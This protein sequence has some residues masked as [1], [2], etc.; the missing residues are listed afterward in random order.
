MKLY[1]YLQRLAFRWSS[2]CRIH[3]SKKWP[4][5]WSITIF[6]SNFKR[7]LDTNQLLNWASFCIRFIIFK[8]THKNLIRVIK[9]LNGKVDNSA[10]SNECS[11]KRHFPF[12]LYQWNGLT[13]VTE[14]YMDIRFMMVY[15]YCFRKLARS[16]FLLLTVKIKFSDSFDTINRDVGNNVQYSEFLWIWIWPFIQLLW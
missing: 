1:Q 15:F 7:I 8:K 4:F 11:L 12:S 6:M 5:L 2:F 3:S 16:L 9:Q 10:N 13:S 14:I